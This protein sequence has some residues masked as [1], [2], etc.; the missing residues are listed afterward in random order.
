MQRPVPE[1]ALKT[2]ERNW[3]SCLCMVDLCYRS[4]SLA[5]S[6]LHKG[7]FHDALAIRYN[8]S[9]QHAPSFCACGTKFSLEH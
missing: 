2:L 8:W 6:A 3:K 9:P 1:P 5:F 4:L 7:A